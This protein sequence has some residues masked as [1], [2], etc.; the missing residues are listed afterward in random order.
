MDQE[1]KLALQQYQ[2][3]KFTIQAGIITNTID[4][5]TEINSGTSS[6][7]KIA[8]DLVG[9]VSLLNEDRELFFTN[10]TYP[11]DLTLPDDLS[12]EIVNYRFQKVDNKGY[13]TT[14]GKITHNDTTLYLIAVFDI[15]SIIE[16]QQVLVLYFT[17]AYIIV[18]ISTMIL[19]FILSVFLTS[20]IKRMTKAAN[21][22]ASGRYNER[23]PVT[24]R[25]EIGE[26]A[27]SFNLMATAVEEIMGK[28]SDAVKQK[29]DFVANFAH[30]L[31]TPLTSII[32]YADMLYQKKLSPEEV[33]KSAWYVLSESMRLESLSLKLMDLIILD[34]QDFILE[35]MP[36]Q[37]LMEHIIASLEP[38]FIDKKIVFQMDIDQAYLKVDYDLFATLLLNLVD[39]AMKA[40]SSHI[41]MT[42]RNR[43]ENFYLQILDNGRG[44]P[45]A[46]MER[47][48]EAFYVVDKSRSR[49]Q[50]GAGL[51]LALVD[52]IVKVHKGNITFKSK[53]TKGTLVEI[54]LPCKGV[55][56]VE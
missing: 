26:L 18:L 16:Q 12:E 45:S 38:V 33:K 35:E 37:E 54:S 47:I 36:T 5:Q 52:K 15:S 42:G 11:I 2:Y 56:Y 41:K 27:E 4:I 39:N 10:I 48:K 43:N 8:S 14:Y 25:D 29:D 51:G 50:H 3:N 21:R 40:G 31:K 9:Q 7:N 55:E 22:I 44:I 13:I 49:R 46:E 20:P 17:S 6:F 32:G 24:R 34:H 23:L 28:L 30:E 1:K 19:L 53:E